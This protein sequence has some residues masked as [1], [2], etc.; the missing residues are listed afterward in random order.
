MTDARVT[1][2]MLEARVAGNGPRV[3]G[4]LVAADPDE[5]RWLMAHGWAESAGADDAPA[6]AA[7][8]RRLAAR[9]TR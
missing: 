2:R 3:A 1:V 7:V 6:V 9:R 5:A 4:E 8:D